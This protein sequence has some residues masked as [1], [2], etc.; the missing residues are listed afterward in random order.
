MKIQEVIKQGEVLS[1]I[2]NYGAKGKWLL[3]PP[4]FYAPQSSSITLWKEL[5]VHCEFMKRDLEILLKNETEIQSINLSG[6]PTVAKV[7]TGDDK[8]FMLIGMISQVV[9]SLDRIHEVSSFLRRKCSFFGITGNFYIILSRKHNFASYFLLKVGD[10]KLVV[11]MIE[12]L[13]LEGIKN[14]EFLAFRDPKVEIARAIIAKPLNFFFNGKL[15]E[16]RREDF[17]AVLKE[18]V[19][20]H[21]HPTFYEIGT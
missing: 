12:D 8:K 1:L 11:D 13:I 4:F 16:D 17:L 10:V 21:P 14:I 6:Y 2:H 3:F 19:K 15:G 5:K 7:L 18:T 9:N 20:D